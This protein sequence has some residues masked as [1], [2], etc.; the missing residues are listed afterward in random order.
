MD[1]IRKTG[2]NMNDRNKIRQLAEDGHSAEIIGQ[3][4]LIDNDVV[5]SF[6]PKKGKK[7]KAEKEPDFMK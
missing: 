7:K 4:L 1:E 2:V 6:M 5:A 3:M